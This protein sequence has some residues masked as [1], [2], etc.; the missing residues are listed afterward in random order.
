MLEKLAHHVKEWRQGDPLDPANKLGVLVDSD[1]HAKVQSYLDK[2]AKAKLPVIAQ[3]THDG[4]GLLSSRWK[5]MTASLPKKKSL[6]LCYLLSRVNSFEEAILAAN[7]TDYGLA[8]SLFT[9]N[10]KHAIR[11]AKAIKAGTVTVNSYGEGD[12]ST[13]FG[14]YKQSGFGGVIMAWQPMTNSPN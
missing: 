6:A 5:V 8:A 13:P 2:A 4:I 11:G 14:G 1:H 12:A 7:Q 3:S 10:I 9:A